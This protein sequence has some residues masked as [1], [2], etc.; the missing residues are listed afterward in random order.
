MFASYLAIMLPYALWHVVLNECVVACFLFALFPYYLCT[1]LVCFLGQGITKFDCE[2]VNRASWFIA[3]SLACDIVA[4]APMSHFLDASSQHG[5][6][7]VS[8]TL[9]M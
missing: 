2:L 4:N 3:A 6:K 9:A 8:I 7:V 5:S 1:N